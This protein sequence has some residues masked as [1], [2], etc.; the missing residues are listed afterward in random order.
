MAHVITRPQALAGHVDAC[1]R[2]GRTRARSS[3]ATIASLTLAL[4]CDPTSTNDGQSAPSPPSDAIAAGN[5][6]DS[7]PSPAPPA[8]A[9]PQSKTAAA[10]DDPT[11]TVGRTRVD[12]RGAKTALERAKLASMGAAEAPLELRK[13][14]RATMLYGVPRFGK[15]YRG[16]LPHGEV[17]GVYERV[18]AKDGDPTCGGEGWARVGPSAFVCLE[19]TTRS[20]G[21]PRDLPVLAKG[22]RT[23]HYYA[24]VRRKG[25]DGTHPTAPRWRNQAAL[26]R[27]EDPIDHL[28]PEHDY[29]FDRRR[30]SRNGTL[31]VD[32]GFRVVREAD[33]RRLEPSA[34]AGRDVVAKPLPDHGRL[35]WSLSWP[36]APV[37]V[38]PR[39]DAPVVGKQVQQAEFF[40]AD[41]VV[42][43]K[44][45]DWVAVLSPEVEAGAEPERVGWIDAEQ[46][47]RWYEAPRPAGVDDEELWIDV[48]LEQQTLAVMIGDAPIFVTMIASGNH[49][50]PTPVGLYRIRSKMA[51]ATMDSQPGD[52]EAYSVES[53]PWAQFFYKRYGLHGTFWHNRFGRRTSHGCVNLSAHDAAVV[54]AMTSPHPAPGWSM[55]FAHD[56]VPGTVVRIRK[57]NAPV[58][59]RRGDPQDAQTG[60][61]IVGETDGDAAPTSTD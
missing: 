60:E 45:I 30:P 32:K 36:H 29:A 13:S 24:R 38:Q 34:F 51:T 1:T 48:E 33:V 47:R 50:H 41:E 3:L 8:A 16:K 59:D 15:P 5:D 39:P 35:A 7:K 42:R 44:G 4:A 27:G 43:R 56:N 55:A 49:K 58:P 31:L 11:P 18:A 12:P 17:F 57:M 28:L 26:A 46:I 6:G 10:P 52:E 53:V 54:Y 21:K 23:P 22:Q 61:P 37:L 9:E 20:K 14:T 19:H 40:V 2:A 25:A